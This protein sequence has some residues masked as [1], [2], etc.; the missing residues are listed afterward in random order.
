[1]A[2]KLEFG[3]DYTVN[4]DYRVSIIR[5]S[6][7]SSRIALSVPPCLPDG[8]DGSEISSERCRAGP[9]ASGRCKS[10]Y[11]LTLRS[12]GCRRLIL[13][14]LLIMLV[15]SKC[16]Y[17]FDCRD[18]YMCGEPCQLHTKLMEKLDCCSVADWSVYDDVRSR[19]QEGT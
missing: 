17:P 13:C 2:L 8:L 19:R 16:T 18:R 9:T 5:N 6:R 1:M 11:L 12:S 14:S 3:Q 7:L 10:Q 15:P 4:R